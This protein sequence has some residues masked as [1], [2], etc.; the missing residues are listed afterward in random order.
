MNNYDVVPVEC[1]FCERIIPREYV[2][3]HIPYCNDAPWRVT[4][5]KRAQK[6]NGEY[7]AE[8]ETE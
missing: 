1:P 3:Y 7:Q 4:S 8:K 5:R 2:A 6:R